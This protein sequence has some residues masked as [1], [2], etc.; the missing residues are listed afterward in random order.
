[1]RKFRAAAAVAAM[2]AGLGTVGAGTAFAGGEPPALNQTNNQ[3][4]ET[5]ATQNNNAL[6]GDLAVAL[7]IT[8]LGQAE[9]EA[10]S[11]DSNAATCEQEAGNEL[12]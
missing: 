9:A 2:V 8:I 3:A 6:I 5:E 4:C 10:S 11:A 12:D 1:M 7:P